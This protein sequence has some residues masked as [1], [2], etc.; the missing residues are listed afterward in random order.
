MQINYSQYKLIECK[1]ARRRQETGKTYHLPAAFMIMQTILTHE[2]RFQRA[3]VGAL[4]VVGT[5]EG[6]VG[7]LS[8]R[9]KESSTNCTFFQ[10]HPPRYIKNNAKRTNPFCGPCVSV[11][12]H[13]PL[14]FIQMRPLAEVHSLY[15]CCC[16]PDTSL[17][18]SISFTFS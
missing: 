11:I 17:R 3:S 4:P 7:L 18:L 10:P 12:W 15:T 6:W 8:L 2:R 13:D 5:P 16:S 14:P 1:Q 9:L